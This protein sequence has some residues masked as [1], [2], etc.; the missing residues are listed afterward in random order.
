MPSKPPKVG[1][2]TRAWTVQSI[3]EREREPLCRMCKAVGRITEA[4]CIDHKVP[5][6]DGGSL[7]DPENLQ[8]LCS[9][10]H[11][12][13]SA[14]EARDRPVSR[15]PYPSEGW[16]VLGAPGAGKS[17]VVQQHA[18]AEDFV[19]DHD[20]VLASLRG[21]EWN[22]GPSG[23]SK[24]LA[25]MGR[26]RRS[27]L[28]AW[29]DGFMPARLWWITTSVDEARDLKR[30]FPS[31]RLRV[32]RA[33]LDELAHRIEARS[34]LTPTQRAEMLGAARNIAAS[35]DASGISSDGER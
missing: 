2:Q 15:G 14:I 31:V 9:A 25:F 32:V 33:S 17:T 29:R 35:I 1:H 10:C 11:R 6:A 27:V 13:K 3:T 8:P 5:L 26:L 18:A 28:E 16:I 23:D 34:W 20:R 21:R 4:V 24:A 30:E 7:H 19:W 22:G 12:K